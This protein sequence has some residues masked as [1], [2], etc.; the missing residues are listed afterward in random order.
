MAAAGIPV[1]DVPFVSVGG[2][3]GSFVTGGL[4]AHRRDAE[5]EHPGTDEPQTTRG[6]P[7]STSPGCRRSRGPSGSDRTPRRSPD[8]IW[9]F[10]SYALQEAVRDRTVSPLWQVLVEPVFADFYTPRLGTVLAGVEREAH[11]IGYQDT[12]VN[13]E[14]R[15]VRRRVGGGYFTVLTPPE[16]RHVVSQADRVPVPG[17]APRRRLPRAEVPA[18]PAAVPD[19]ARRTSSTWSTRTRTTSTSTPRCGAARAR[20]WSGRR[21]RRLPDPGAADPETGSST[22]CRLGSS[23]CCRNHVDGSHGPHPWSRRRG[24]N[25]FAY[26]GFNYPKSVWGGQLQG[27]DAAPRRRPSGRRRTPRWAAPPRRSGAAGNA[28]SPRDAAR[29][30]YRT[31][32]GTIEQMRSRGPEPMLLRIASDEGPVEVA[33]RLRHRLHRP[34]GRRLRAPGARRPAPARRRRPQPARPPRRGAHLRVARDGQR[35]RPA[36]RCPARP[37]SAAT[38]PASTPSS[39]CRSPPRRSPTTWPGAGCAAGSERCARSCSGSSG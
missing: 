14:V 4:P 28:S 13:G 34:G 2:G 16:A 24:G 36:L 8:N 15:M 19:G 18:G 23:T 9:G 1:R 30:W 3:I 5:L 25:G 10:P 7:T 12:V 38:S 31:A 39:A 33:R 29:G 32:T 26:Q 27:P 20:S 37:P 35:E 21:D 11:R 6:R 17:R 22:A